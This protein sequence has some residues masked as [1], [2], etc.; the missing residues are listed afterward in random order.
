MQA[1]RL[2]GMLKNYPDAEV[3]V[4]SS[5]HNGNIEYFEIIMTV[6]DNKRFSLCIEKDDPC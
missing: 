5:D 1:K 3:N 4:S 6:A 2:I